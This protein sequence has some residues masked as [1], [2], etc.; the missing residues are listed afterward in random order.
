MSDP[1]TGMD[2]KLWR[3]VGP[4]SKYSARNDRH[5]RL[6]QVNQDPVQELRQS[7]PS[8]QVRVTYSMRQIPTSIEVGGPETRPSQRKPIGNSY[9]DEIHVNQGG[10]QISI[11]LRKLLVA[12]SLATLR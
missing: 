4:T 1:N 3:G 5:G 10:V 2:C 9:F 12:Y 11:F 7:T 8:G 6:V